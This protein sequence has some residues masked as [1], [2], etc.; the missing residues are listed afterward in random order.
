MAVKVLVVDDSAMIRQLLSELLGGDPR[1]VVVGAAHDPYHAREMIKSLKPDV[2]TLDVEMPR[3]DG[4]TFLDHLMRLHPMPV[5]MVSSL[6]QAGADAALRALEL[7]AVD[8]VAKPQVGIVQGLREATERLREAVITAAGARLPSRVKAPVRR[9]QPLSLSTDFFFVLGAS[10]G[11]TEA[12]HDVIAALPPDAPGAVIVQHIPP[13]FSRTFAERLDRCCAVRVGEAFDG[14]R[15]ATGQVWVAPGGVQLRIRRDGARY[16]C[17]LGE[18]TRVNG[19]APS[20]DVMFDSAA[21][22]AGGNL[23]AALLTGM[24]DDG[25]RGLTRLRQAGAFTCVQ[26]EASSVVWGMP[27]A[28][29]RLGGAEAVLPLTDVAD[30][31]MDAARRHVG[32]LNASSRAAAGR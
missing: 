15:I 6:T 25:A 21:E 24:G 30:R 11:G 26:D 10:T 3:M 8:I 13:M 1:I 5:V 19:F 32:R 12:L 14:A 9:P 18:D 7:G 22:A 2:I 27:G 20:V 23:A 28:A 4:L 29:V 16:V 17:R 31:L